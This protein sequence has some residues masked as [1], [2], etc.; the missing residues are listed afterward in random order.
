MD[1]NTLFTA[2]IPALITGVISYFSA[3]KKTKTE[4]NK[5]KLDQEIALK[6]IETEQKIAIETIERSSK[7]EIEKM[8][9][10]TIEEI[11]LY[12]AKSQTDLKSI[13]D[14]MILEETQKMFSHLF[15]SGSSEENQKKV[16]DNL[17]EF[18]KKYAK[19]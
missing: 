4:L 13:E 16:M 10:Q 6:K 14:R 17:N 9:R 5:A 3:S 8:R 19:K 15:G 11:Q 2:S 7:N 12:N 1:W 18:N